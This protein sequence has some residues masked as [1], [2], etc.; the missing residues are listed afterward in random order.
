MILDYYMQ[1]QLLTNWCW[2]AVS[3]A[4]SRFYDADTEWSQNNIAT[5]VLGVDCS[6]VSPPAHPIECNEI[7]ALEDALAAS[8]NLREPPTDP[9]DYVQI[10]AEI[11]NG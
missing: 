11:D 9:L 7:A 5:A 10:T 6:V 3:A 4:I 8:G 1:K 2:S